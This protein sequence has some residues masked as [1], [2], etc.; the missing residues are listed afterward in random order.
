M[1]AQRWFNQ[2]GAPN[3]L[4]TTLLLLQHAGHLEQPTLASADTVLR[5]GGDWWRDW[6]GYNLVSLAQLNVHRGLLLGNASLVDAGF[7]AVWGQLALMAWPPPPDSGTRS[8]PCADP[9]LAEHTCGPATCQ[10]GGGRYLGDGLQADAS[11]HQHGQQLE[12]G[13]YGTGLATAFLGFLPRTRGLR[14][15]CPP[16]RL[17]AL[18]SLLL[19]GM[20]RMTLPDGAHWDWQVV[21]R[22]NSRP[23]ASAHIG[24]SSVQ[25]RF[26]ATLDAARADDY[27]AFADALDGAAPSL[28]GSISFPRSDYHV[29]RRAGWVGTWKAPHVA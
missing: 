11:Y 6:S 16:A 26:A 25:L 4:A 27:R 13:G 22:D 23:G 5:R 7:D 10:V 28:D 24:I 9:P 2:I 14:W 29:H 12:D 21:G 8:A 3:S 18:A 15:A 20:R 17:D 1:L 19:D